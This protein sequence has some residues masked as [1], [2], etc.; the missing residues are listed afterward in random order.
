MKEHKI[1]FSGTAGA[2]KTRAIAAIS[3]TA[4]VSTDVA[5]SDMS[6]GK[7]TTT[8]GLDFGTIT[9]A[10]GDRVRLFGTPGQARFDFMW[11][12]LARDALGLILLIDNSRPF[13]LADLQVYLDG[14]AGE[15][16]RMPCVV[17]VG[18]TEA[19]PSPTLDAF[20]DHLTQRNLVLP[21]VAVDVRRRDDVLMLIDLLLAQ[22][23]ASLAEDAP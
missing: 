2:G 4:P 3:D 22:A 12:I 5:N 20:A 7:P 16:E 17:G 18:R 13:P 23:E 11:P 15:L 1:L 19:H 21:V 6:L 14:F 10:S 9:L 8:V